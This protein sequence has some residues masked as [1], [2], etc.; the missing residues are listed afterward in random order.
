MPFCRFWCLQNGKE[1]A[2]VAGVDI[3][4]VERGTGH[5]CREDAFWWDHRA[6]MFYQSVP[7]THP[8][9][10]LKGMVHSVLA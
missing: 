6:L 9:Q 3:Y 4:S 2:A 7:V 1:G 5:S 10:H 8:H